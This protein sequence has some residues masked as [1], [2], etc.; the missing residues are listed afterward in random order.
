MALIKEC[1]LEKKAA[2][3]VGVHKINVK[4]GRYMYW[5]VF[6]QPAN[7]VNYDSKEW[8]LDIKMRL[9]L[10][11]T[12]SFLPEATGRAVVR[13]NVLYEM[14]NDEVQLRGARIE[15]IS[16]VPGMLKQLQKAMK[17]KAGKLNLTIP[18]KDCFS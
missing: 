10:M 2:K 5:L 11:T 12:D 18:I 6:S 4:I 13:Y 14:V 1:K 9:S 7:V 16:F 8:T 15:E 17:K 3:K